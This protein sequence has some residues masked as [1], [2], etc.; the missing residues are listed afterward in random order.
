MN[1]NKILNNFIFEN[2]YRVGGGKEAVYIKAK[3]EDEAIKKAKS[4]LSAKPDRLG[5]S[6]ELPKNKKLNQVFPEDQ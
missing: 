5:F 1:E 6:K 4:L 2:I 3:N